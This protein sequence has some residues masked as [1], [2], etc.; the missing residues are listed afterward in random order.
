ME[1]RFPMTMGTMVKVV[2]AMTVFMTFV[3]LPVQAAMIFRFV[4]AGPFRWLM[5]GVFALTFGVLAFTFL[6]APRGVRLSGGRL[7]VERWLWSDFSVPLRTL[8]SVAPGPELRLMTGE[9][10]RVAGNGGLM[11]FTGLFHVRDVG[12]VRCWATQLARPTVL[13]RRTDGRPLLLGVDDA[14]GLMTALRRAGVNAA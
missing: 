14:S 11:G 7:V 5:V 2:T 10:R 4:P 13:V 8:S 1:T 12:V 6:L 9:V 3:L